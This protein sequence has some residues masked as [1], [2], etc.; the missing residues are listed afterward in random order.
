MI[1]TGHAFN[2][3]PPEAKME[4]TIRTFELGVRDTVLKRFEEIVHGVAAAMGC[5][6]QVN[7]KRLTPAMINADEIA[8][9]VQASARHTLPEADLDTSNHLT[10]GAEDMA[11]TLEK[12]PGCY[13][14][15]G[16]ANDEKNLN[17]GH[18]HPKFD[19]DEGA[20]PRAA[21]LMASAV[22]DFLK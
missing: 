19:F 2:V 12:I 18:H 15:V 10:M 22:V 21:A 5:T 13:F 8:Q 16:S 14:F 4:G 20:L 1:H 7:V 9:R 3:I 17:Y 6:V 11:F